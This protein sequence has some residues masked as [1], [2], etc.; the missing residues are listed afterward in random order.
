MRSKK[1]GGKQS[2]I[3]LVWTV[4]AVFVVMGTIFVTA[5]LAR[6][7][8]SRAS[9]AVSRAKAEALSHAALQAATSEV[10][11]SLRIGAEPPQTGSIVIDGE[12]VDFE[13]TKQVGPLEGESSNGLVEARSV[14]RV[15]GSGTSDG[16]T[17]SSRRMV[18]AAVIPIFQFAIFYENDLEFYNPAPWEIQGRVHTNSD[19]YIRTA[20]ELVFDTNY[21]HAAGKMYGRAPH[22]GWNSLS[23]YS[24][25]IRRW[26]PDPFD[27]LQTKEFVDLP[28]IED[29]TSQGIASS[30][31]MDSDFAGQDWGN[32]GSFLESGDVLPFLAHTLEN[33]TPSNPAMGT[34]STLQTGDHGVLPLAPPDIA[35][36][37]MYEPKTGG[38]YTF[39]SAS[40]RYVKVPAG[41]G[42][43]GQG[44]FMKQA[45]LVIQSF[46]DGTWKAFDE[47]GIDVSSDLSAVIKPSTIF[48]RRQAERSSNS[49]QQL[50]IDMAAL[51]ASPHFPTNGLLYMGGYFDGD[52]TGTNVKAFTL[53][54]AAELPAG[55]TVTSPNSVYVQGDYNTVNPK[56]AAVMADA[57]NFLS[58]AWD[59]S[60]TQ[61]NLPKATPTTY[62]LSVISGDVPYS[63]TTPSG[64][65]HNLPR[66][67]EDWDGVDEHLNGSI[68]CPFR[69]RYATSPWG[70]GGDFYRAPNRFWSFDQ[71]NNNINNLPPYTPVTVRVQSTASWVAQP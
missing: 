37:D 38:D 25:K 6:T 61:G 12:T 71:R 17:A 63:S 46:P 68:V 20:N 8:D 32:D 10:A 34:E 60:K 31:G 52:G 13:I 19:M 39:D 9:L 33:W 56:P 51:A 7:A 40:N 48:D 49:L 50:E 43:Y 41:T 5:T 22:A 53:Q 59:N 26:V 36:F 24:P 29:F 30:G 62:N 57:V 67:H 18:Q 23:G 15:V 64:G 21:L 58:N 66:R 70:L 14:Y 4:F 65:P 3:V 1:T 54:N 2:G 44:T 35:N 11:N 69:S 28:I 45:G 42:D 27:P 16:I 55:L 47:L